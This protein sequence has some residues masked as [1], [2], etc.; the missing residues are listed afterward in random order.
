MTTAS[1]IPTNHES[2]ASPKQSS[3]RSGA[4]PVTC[5]LCCEEDT[6]LVLLSTC[7]H[8]SCDSCFVK[9]INR[10]EASKCTARP[11]C[12]FCRVDIDDGDILRVMGRP[13]HPRKGQADAV[14]EATESEDEID[15][16]TLHWINQN[17]MPCRVCGNRVERSEGCDYIECLCG[18]QFCYRCGDAYVA[19]HC[20]PE[21]DPEDAH[22][23]NE[24]EDAPIR[25]RDG[26]INYRLCIRRREVKEE[27]DDRLGETRS[28][29]RHSSEFP[30]VCTSNGRWLFSSKN[31][32]SCV[33]MLTQQLRHERI[34]YERIKPQYDEEAGISN[35]AWLFLGR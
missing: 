1:S 23:I 35:A 16:L 2:N 14:R 19:C 32:A 20:N 26:H 17:T 4:A 30:S 34:M 13:F 8:Q 15:E 33:A 3:I 9:W 25:D 21:D 10:E 7:H 11:T 28:H 31:N 22:S 5:P 24:D 29:W 6:A 12:P 18:H 27:R